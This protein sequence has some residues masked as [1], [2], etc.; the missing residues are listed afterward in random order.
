MKKRTFSWIKHSIY[1]RLLFLLQNKCRH[2]LPLCT[3]V[4]RISIKCRFSISSFLSSLR[5]SACTIAAL[6]LILAN[7]LFRDRR[8][9]VSIRWWKHR[10]TVFAFRLRLF[11]WILCIIQVPASLWKSNLVDSARVFLPP[12]QNL[13]YLCFWQV[14]WLA[15]P[16]RTSLCPRFEHYFD[17]ILTNTPPLRI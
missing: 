13:P 15:L 9:A 4:S 2:I 14:R 7:L 16:T 17:A 11:L 5:G 8:S 3:S 1:M 6:V 10:W 12:A